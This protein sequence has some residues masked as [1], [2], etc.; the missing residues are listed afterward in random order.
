MTPPGFEPETCGTEGQSASSPLGHQAPR[1]M[2]G[3]T[4]GR[5]EREGRTTEGR[6]E[7]WTERRTAGRMDGKK[8]GRKEGWT[9]GRTDER[10]LQFT[11]PLN[12]ESSKFRSQTFLFKC[13]LTR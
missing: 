3:R 13:G 7:G 2:D 5:M 8:D 1:W 4:E 11:L 9:E 6:P 12:C 10:T